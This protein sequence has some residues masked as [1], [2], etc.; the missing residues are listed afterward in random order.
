MLVRIKNNKM[1]KLLIPPEGK[2]SSKIYVNV[3]SVYFKVFSLLAAAA[4][5]YRQNGQN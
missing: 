2:L 5:G 4:K 3:G 1:T